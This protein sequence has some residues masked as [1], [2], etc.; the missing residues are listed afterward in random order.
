MSRTATRRSVST[1][2]ADGPVDEEF[3][4]NLQAS[5]PATRGRNRGKS[6]ARSLSFQLAYAS[7]D[8]FLVCAIGVLLLWALSLWSGRQLFAGPHGQPYVGIFLLYA[9][10]VVLG[11]GTQDLYR[12]PRD[13]RVLHQRLFITK[14]T[15]L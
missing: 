5:Q 4:R 9:A 2:H 1:P 11:C 14:A 13:P 6:L 12:T 8:A 10:L 3:L 7:I 15:R